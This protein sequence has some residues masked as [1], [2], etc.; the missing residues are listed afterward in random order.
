MGK[1]T[2]IPPL[3][4]TDTG[5][6]DQRKVAEIL[7]L[8][9]LIHIMATKEPKK[10]FDL[11]GFAARYE[12]PE[13]VHPIRRTRAHMALSKAGLPDESLADML[14]RLYW[15]GNQSTKDMA[16]TLGSTGA[17]VLS[18]M[19]SCGI[20]TRPK[21]HYWQ[22]SGIPEVVIDEKKVIR[23]R[24][25]LQN[26]FG[27]DYVSVLTQMM[28]EGMKLKEIAL[29]NKLVTARLIR[30]LDLAG[31]NVRPSRGS[32]RERRIY[33]EAKRRGFLDDLSERDRLIV[34]G[35]FDST[36]ETAD[37]AKKTPN[38]ITQKRGISIGGFNQERKKIISRL[39]ELIEGDIAV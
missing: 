37:L 19:R 24:Q 31:F 8:R 25:K 33:N 34:I 28:K 32:V 14:Y 20:R 5:F 15:V 22:N 36:T 6:K 16:V 18:W 30:L 4:I 10:K 3:E 11:P 39:K 12:L 21:H 35:Y 17:T 2:I 26:V 9:T 1:E 23:A 13:T 29:K 38:E 27:Q 7:F